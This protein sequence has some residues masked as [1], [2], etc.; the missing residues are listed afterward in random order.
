ML[1]LS[2]VTYRIEKRRLLDRANA[3]IPDGAKVGLVGRNGVGK[4]TLLD[5]IRGVLR[6]GR[7]HDR[8]AG[9]SAHRLSGTGSAR[10]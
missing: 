7:R 2:D 4:S 1:T 3:Q 6:A 9:Q 8:I 10:G 5:L